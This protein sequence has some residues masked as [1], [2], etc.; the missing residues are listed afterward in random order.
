MGKYSRR[1]FLKVA[2]VGAGALT[3]G[4]ILDACGQTSPTSIPP[5]DTAL[6]ST[7][8]P[9]TL[10]P[11]PPET[12]QPAT[13]TAPPPTNTPLPPPD[14]VVTSGGEPELLVRQ[15]ILALGGMEKFV[16]IGSNVIIKPNICVA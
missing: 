12:L 10:S 5:T 3:L 9:A 1:N 7:Q 13:D 4:S 11:F 2:A 8:Q 14:L 15:A 16:P 6:P